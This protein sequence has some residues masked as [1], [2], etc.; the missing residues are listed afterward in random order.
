M[1]AKRFGTPLKSTSS[2]K[3]MIAMETISGTCI[4]LL[5]KSYK[6]NNTFKQTLPDAVLMDLDVEERAGCFA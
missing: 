3:N 2:F 4:S 6:T 5:F 1:V